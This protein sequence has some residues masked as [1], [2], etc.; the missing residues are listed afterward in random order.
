MAVLSLEVADNSVK[1]KVS[2]RDS[3]NLSIMTQ[4]N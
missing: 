3:N 4:R 2:L 1:Q